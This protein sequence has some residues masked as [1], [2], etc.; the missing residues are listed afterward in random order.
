MKEYQNECIR[1]QHAQCVVIFVDV[2]ECVA[3]YGFRKRESESGNEISIAS[4]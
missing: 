2:G 3:Y 4:C 1:L